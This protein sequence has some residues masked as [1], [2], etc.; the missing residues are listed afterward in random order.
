MSVRSLFSL[1][2]LASLGITLGF[3]YFTLRI[4]W[5]LL[6]GVVPATTTLLEY[7]FPTYF[8]LLIA[9]VFLFF[10]LMFLFSFLYL[11][12]ERLIVQPINIIAGAMHEFAEHSHQVELPNFSSTTNEVKWLSKVFLEFTGSVERVHARDMEV[13]RMKSDFI[14][15]AA[16]QLRTPMTGI[17]WALEALQKSS[18]TQDQQQ[19]ADSATAKSKELVAIVG[20]LLDISA[21]ESGKYAY[22]FQAVDVATLL[23]DIAQ[24]FSV[25]AHTRNVAIFFVKSEELIPKAK[26]DP[27]RIK[28][29]LSNLIENAIRYTPADGSVQLSLS[30]GMGRV[31]VK[32]KDTGIG[33]KEEDRNSIF[34]RFYRAQNAI[35]KEQAGNGLGLYIARTI[36]KDH[37]GDLLFLPNTDGPGTTFTFSL[38]V[39][40]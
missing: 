25:M 35:E 24:E 9:G 39:A 20:T 28:W 27:E 23:Q 3:I 31:I 13:S 17:R 15:T 37:G 22:K 11:L 6:D 34:E 26:A 38:A 14:S 32:V 10:L 5:L 33:I 12:I 8:I 40:R 29:V 7:S 19:L 2:F 36:A 16:H 21:I 18:L 1:L 30:T 4:V